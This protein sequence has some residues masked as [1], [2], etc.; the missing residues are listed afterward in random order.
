M[1]ACEDTRAIINRLNREIVQFLSRADINDKFLAAGTEVVGSS[2]R[3]FAVT[4]KND[5]SK[6]GKVIRNAGIR[7]E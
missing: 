7:A 1:G 5:M 4:I 3:D 6:W 2:P